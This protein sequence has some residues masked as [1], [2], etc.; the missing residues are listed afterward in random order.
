[1]GVL[2]VGQK[3]EEQA[4]FE[5]IY[6]NGGYNLNIHNA[7]QSSLSRYTVKNAVFSFSQRGRTTPTPV[8]N[9]MQEQEPWKPTSPGNDLALPS[10]YMQWCKRAVLTFTHD[11]RT[12]KRTHWGLVM[13][14]WN[15]M[16]RYYKNNFS[17]GFR[18]VRMNSLSSCPSV[19]LCSPRW[20]LSSLLCLQDS[21][22][23][24]LGNYTVDETDGMMALHM[25]KDWKFLMVSAFS[26]LF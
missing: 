4:D 14:G 26:I 17:D 8:R 16:I 11:L 22:D 24:F 25:Q 15:S 23:L 18:Q 6:K 10:E 2:H 20:M 21:I 12:G 5:K 13:D 9:N 1:M 3:I 19:R 7:N